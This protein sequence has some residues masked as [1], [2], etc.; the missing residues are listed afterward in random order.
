LRL[1]PKFLLAVQRGTKRGMRKFSRSHR[2]PVSWRSSRNAKVPLRVRSST[3]SP[4]MLCR[5]SKMPAPGAALAEADAVAGA[6][7]AWFCGGG[8]AEEEEG[9]AAPRDATVPGAR[10]PLDVTDVGGGS[11]WKACQGPAQSSAHVAAVYADRPQS[12]CCPPR[13]WRKADFLWCRW[14]LVQ[15]FWSPT[16]GGSAVMQHTTLTPQP[17]AKSW[18]TLAPMYD[19][20]RLA[21]SLRVHALKPG[22]VGAGC[23]A[24]VAVGGD[25]AGGPPVA[26][27]GPQI[28]VGVRR[29]RRDRTRACAFA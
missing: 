26:C 12:Q 19:P 7:D 6:F 15:A 1:S 2:Q 13:L 23:V 11:R 16:C 29:W 27:R 10:A 9:A 17:V 22:L 21:C 25:A 18:S 24:L 5:P 28:T 20:A 8:R 4:A 14:R 3:R